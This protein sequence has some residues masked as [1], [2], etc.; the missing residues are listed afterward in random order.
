MDREVEDKRKQKETHGDRKRNKQTRLLKMDSVLYIAA[1]LEYVLHMRGRQGN[2]KRRE[3][4]EGGG[5]KIRKEK[6]EEKMGEERRREE[7]KG[8]ES[9]HVHLCVQT[10]CS[11]RPMTRQK[12]TVG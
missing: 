7:K 12:R 10:D 2:E 8:E 4:K 3:E 5:E 6:R 1:S 9:R 11:H